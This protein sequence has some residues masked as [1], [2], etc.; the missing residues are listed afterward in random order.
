MARSGIPLCSRR[1]GMMARRR[2]IG[3]LA[4]VT[5]SAILS[6]CKPSKPASSTYRFKMTVEVETP[7]GIK[8]GSGILEAQGLRTNNI[9]TGGQGSRTKLEGE[10][11]AV[12][13]APGKTLFA[14]LRMANGTSS[15]DNLAI[16]SMKAMDPAYNHDRKL[17]AQRIV[18]GDGIRSPADVAPAD[19]PMLVTFGENNDPTSVTR[20]DPEGL[21]FSFG[22]GVRLKRIR[23]EVTDEAAT[24]GIEKRLGW[25]PNVY[26]MLRGTDFQ[27]KDIPVGDFKSLF[28]TELSK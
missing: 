8:T 12:D 21:G 27:P 15:D 9:D 3:L 20:V 18:S 19:Y 26:S 16:M 1:G 14:L 24:S 5:L 13:I 4:G 17:S 22:T 10:A 23:V 28:S 2:V 6:A 7:T 25:L 11:I